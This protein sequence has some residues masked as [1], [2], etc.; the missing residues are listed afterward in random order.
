MTA[1]NVRVPPAGQADKER[2]L[3]VKNGQRFGHCET[4]LVQRLA[5]YHTVEIRSFQTHQT[6]EV[7]KLPDTPGVAEAARHGARY[8][9][10]FIQVGATQHPV[11]I[12]VRVHQLAH[13]L[14]PELCDNVLSP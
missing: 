2:R 8:A 3:T 5:D 1:T 7:G 9:S 4:S 14:I 6:F 10:H 11:T 12:H 13:P